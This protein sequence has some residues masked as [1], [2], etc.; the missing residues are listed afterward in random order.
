MC[1]TTVR[2]QLRLFLFLCGLLL[3]DRRSEGE[4]TFPTQNAAP[5]SQQHKLCLH[6]FFPSVLADRARTQGGVK[7]VQVLVSNRGL[8][9]CISYNNPINSEYRCK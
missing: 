2:T 9:V 1:T 4:I 6:W 7:Y 5:L 8:E 3:T